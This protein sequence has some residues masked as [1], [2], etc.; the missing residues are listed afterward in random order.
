MLRRFAVPRRFGRPAK[1]PIEAYIK[2]I[3][4]EAKTI[5][6]KMDGCYVEI[7][8]S[9]SGKACSLRNFPRGHSLGSARIVKSGREQRQIR[10]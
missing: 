1:K 4:D 8:A 6:R 7:L 2:R 9:V 10:H 5:K 3:R